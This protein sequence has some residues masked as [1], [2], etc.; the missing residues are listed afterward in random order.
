MRK[1]LFL[2]VGL[3]AAMWANVACAVSEQ[4]YFVELGEELAK[5]EVEAKWEELRSKHK[6]Q[7]GKLK[8]FPKDVIREGRSVGVRM[9]AGPIPLKTAASKICSKMFSVD[10]PCFVIEG[11]NDMPPMALMDLNDS[12][13]KVPAA[14]IS[15]RADVAA[16]PAV[17]E[18]ASF[19]EL[20]WLKSE[21]K[22]Q[23][24]A[25]DAAPVQE[26][27]A[28]QESQRKRPTENIQQAELSKPEP[29]LEPLLQEAEQ[30][31]RAAKVQVAEAIRVPLSDDSR[32]SPSGSI[33]VNSLPELKPSAG[34]PAARYE[35]TQDAAQPEE[36]GS[37]DS[38]AGRLAVAG[39][40]NDEVATSLWDEIRSAYP[41]KAKPLQASVEEQPGAANRQATLMVATFASSKQALDFC[42]EQ[43]QAKERGL[44]CQ[45]MPN[46]SGVASNQTLTLNPA[47][48]DAYQARRASTSAA[49]VER[50]R[51][52]QNPPS[53]LSPSAGVPANQYWVQVAT[54]ASQ[55]D[56]LKKW[57]TVKADH[58]EV[59]G[60]LRSSVSQSSTDKSTYVVRVG[61]IMNNDD[62][63]R[64]CSQL[65]K[66]NVECRV[67][68]Y[69]GSGKI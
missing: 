60:A 21:K 66:R 13:A 17:K 39:F 47:R 43:I 34:A 18:E 61:P 3:G 4:E 68:L 33:L 46:D 59:L 10:V 44:S 19:F 16:A 2:A 45:F 20:P 42:R 40:L 36:T 31:K 65:Q 64:V 62:A 57:D 25:A 69:S 51:P 50:R 27:P 67:L 41:K 12:G 28:Q 8:L 26:K 6:T 30:P 48:G 38:G 58:A 55:M 7:L 37:E 11:V 53:E 56:A 49:A 52:T 5:D 22:A 35:G 24:P 14:G 9:Q 63:I 15:S 23:Q 54:G 1:S 32:L 29:K